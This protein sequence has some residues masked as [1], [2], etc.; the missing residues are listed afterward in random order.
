MK[1]YDKYKESR[2]SW[3]EEVPSHWTLTQVRREAKYHTGGTPPTG[4][5]SFYDGDRTWITIGD[6]KGRTCSHSAKK[7]TDQTA[8]LLNIPVS[9]KGS[10]LFS[11]KLSVGQ[12]SF[13]GEDVYT[14]EAIA[15]FL[16]KSRISLSYAYYAFPLYIV[17]NASENIYGAKLLNRGL[18]QAAPLALPPKEEQI[19]IAAFLDHETGKIDELIAEQEK[20]IALLDEKRQAVI[21][22][23]VTKG[24]DPNV[25]MKDSGIAWLGK[26]PEHWEVSQIKRYLT[27][28]SGDMI[29]ADKETEIGFPIIG[30]NGVRGYT[31]APNTEGN[32]LVIGR[33]GA[34]CGCVHH[35]QEP[36][37]A[38]EHAFRVKEKKTLQKRF[39]YHLLTSINYNNFAIRTAQPLLNTTII[40]APYV[41][42][43]CIK[44]QEII[45]EY[46]DNLIEHFTVLASESEKAIIL[47]KERRSA[48]ISAAVTGK[49]D[50][51]NHPAA[52]AA[53]N[54]KDN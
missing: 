50:V 8:S 24:L 3:L 20:L 38:S 33:V 41:A 26:V 54:N 51:R 49:I 21:S 25:K 14:N 6:L 47:L 2:I 4:N 27:V 10:L 52:V 28:Q 42:I 46:L 32:A 39:F 44:E 18:I 40:E 17:Q 34:R 9:P 12:V 43:P 30:G 36:F 45:A 7:I 53:L 19:A 5:D 1:A 37:W 11:F 35:I 13:A 22:H 48:L 31:N 23:A 29:S 16:P 15:T